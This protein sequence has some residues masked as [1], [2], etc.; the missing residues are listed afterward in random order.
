MATILQTKPRWRPRGVV[1]VYLLRGGLVARG[2]RRAGPDPKSARQLAQRGRLACAS[3][4]LKHF[5]AVVRRGYRAGQK[6]NGRVVGAYQMALSRI[7]HDGVSCRNGVWRVEYSKVQLSI[8]KSFP[9]S[10][11]A[12]TRKPGR[13]V[14]RWQSGTPSG[15]ACLRVALYHPG[16]GRG[17]ARAIWV[18]NGQKSADLRLPK[19]MGQGV[20]HMWIVLEDEW[21]NSLWNSAY[22]VV[23]ADGR[24]VVITL[25]IGILGRAD[26][27]GGRTDAY[28]GA[29]R[30]VT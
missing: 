6:P 10:G 23:Q 29:P 30:C 28:R 24:V 11:L 2:W 3:A 21:G 18:A 19:G 12:I 25:L 22:C 15:V 27:L 16:Q 4:F 13:L 5:A 7:V 1:S 8:G 20:L 9:L 17:V 26:M 14:V